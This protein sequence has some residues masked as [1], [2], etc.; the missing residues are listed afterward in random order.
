[1]KRGSA[2]ETL[3]HLYHT[4]RA[5][6]AGDRLGHSVARFAGW[7][8]LSKTTWGSARRASLHPR[9]YASTR[10]AGYETIVISETYFY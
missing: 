9:L 2:S 5:R 10:F 4:E 7:Q 1:V 6:E 8:T 3:G